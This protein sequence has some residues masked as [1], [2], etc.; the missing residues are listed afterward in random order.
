MRYGCVASDVSA[1]YSTE[2]F[3][4]EVDERLAKPIPNLLQLNE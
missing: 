4:K 1:T 2:R 3:E